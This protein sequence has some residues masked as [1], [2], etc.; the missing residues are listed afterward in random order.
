MIDKREKMLFFQ[1]L[2]LLFQDTSSI[3]EEVLCSEYASQ[4]KVIV[5]DTE[6]N[7]NRALTLH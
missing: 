7:K 3:L 6:R 2:F 5:M 4:I 1:L